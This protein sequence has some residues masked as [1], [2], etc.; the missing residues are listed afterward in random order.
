[1]PDAPDQPTKLQSDADRI[2]AYRSEIKSGLLR[3]A[4]GMLTRPY[5]SAG[6]G[7]TY[8]DLTD[9]DAI[10]AGAAYLIDGDAEPL[11]NSLLNLL[12]HIGPDGKGQRRIGKDRYSAPPYQIRP[13]LA[14]GCF[15]LS[16]ET[17]D[18]TWLGPEGFE[19]LEAYLLYR[20]SHN[21]G[22]EASSR[23]CT[24]TKASATTRRRTGP[25][26]RTSSKPLTSM[27]R[28][29]TSTPRSPG[30]LR[31]SA[32]NAGHRATPHTRGALQRASTGA[33]ERGGRVLLQPL[34]S[35][36]AAVALSAHQCRACVQPVAA[37]A[38]HR[39][40]YPRSA[41]HRPVRSL[42][43][44]HVERLRHPVAE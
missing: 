26:S 31:E 17:D 44:T 37:L 20:H 3:P 19:Q 23:G 16:R 13:F 15:V 33:L 36:A 4:A 34:H 21:M 32:T 38:R 41:N 43:R 12:E 40:G 22:R 28:W 39:P 29:S 27:P 42:R 11:R 8:P 9:W 2:H 1:M 30:W 35:A 7:Q 18:V 24:S 25:G 14:A 5:L 6:T 10:W